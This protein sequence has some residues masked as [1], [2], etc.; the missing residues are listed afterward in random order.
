MLGWRAYQEI[1]FVEW[2]GHQIHMI[3]VPEANG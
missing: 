2:C 1:S 3:L